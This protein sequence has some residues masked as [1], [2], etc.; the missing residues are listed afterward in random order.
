VSPNIGL[1]L[2]EIYF[3]TALVITNPYNIAKLSLA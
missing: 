3:F 2:G 1:T